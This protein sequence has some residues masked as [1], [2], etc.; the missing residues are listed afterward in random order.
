[1]HSNL[2]VIAQDFRG[3]NLFLYLAYIYIICKVF[4]VLS[5]M[6]VAVNQDQA[7]AEFILTIDLSG[8]L[9]K[10]IYHA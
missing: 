10:T 3:I 4:D 8:E 9:N 5:N 6:Y 7:E 2:K 1:M